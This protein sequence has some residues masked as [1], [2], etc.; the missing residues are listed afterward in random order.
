MVGSRC[1]LTLIQSSTSLSTTSVFRS[2][3]PFLQLRP[4]PNMHLLHDLLFRKPL[5]LGTSRH[6]MTL[7]YSDIKVWWQCSTAMLQYS[8]CVTCVVGSGCLHTAIPSPTPTESTLTCL[9]ETAKASPHLC[10]LLGRQRVP[11]RSH[12]LV[13]SHQK[14]HRVDATRVAGTCKRSSHLPGRRQD[15]METN[16]KA[17]GNT[18]T[19]H[20]SRPLCI[21]V[22]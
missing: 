9:K 7:Q 14:H 18:V 16:E 1:V 11:P 8:A 6:V 13:S 2:S 19:L 20:L 10:D 4:P 3:P 17:G 22:H 15:T 12:P 21:G 5:S